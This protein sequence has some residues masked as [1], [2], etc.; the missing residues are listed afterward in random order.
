MYINL[1]VSDEEKKS[2]IFTDTWTLNTWTMLS[3][4]WIIEKKL[5][6]PAGTFCKRK[7]PGA[8]I[9]RIFTFLA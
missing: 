6:L 9:E 3:E 2:W 8:R 1:P 4:D 7:N 5:K